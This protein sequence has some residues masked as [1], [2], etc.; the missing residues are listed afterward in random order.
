MFILPRYFRPFLVIY[1]DNV[2]VEKSK[3][4]HKKQKIKKQN[5]HKK[6]QQKNSES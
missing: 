4:K 1:D 3:K 2:W 5:K 6:Q